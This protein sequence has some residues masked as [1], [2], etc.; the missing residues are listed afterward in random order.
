MDSRMVISSGHNPRFR[1]ALALRDGRE[2]RRQGRLLIDGSREIERAIG[3]GV[4]VVEAFVAEEAVDLAGVRAWSALR[5]VRAAAPGMVEVTPELLARLA[6]GDRHEGIVVVAEAPAVDLGALAVPES[7]LIAVVERVEKP[8][9]LGAILRSADGAGVDAV[10]VADPTADPWNPNT[11]RASLGTVFTLPL[12]VASAPDVVDWLAERSI[13]VIAAVVDADVGYWEA[14]LTGGVAI[15]VGSESE[16]V[17]SAW[18]GPG[19]AAVR[20]PMLGVADSLNVSVSA[21]LLL[22]EARRQR[23]APPTD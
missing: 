11:I 10:V 1:A 15:V 5:A 6:Y 21:A 18:R 17:T 23:G 9:N 4:R 13:R 8:G 14:D 12:A 7:P 2:R 20:I 19:M 3:A 22:Y 16:G